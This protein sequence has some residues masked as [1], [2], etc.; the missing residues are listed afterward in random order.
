MTEAAA[1][2]VVA[3]A[4]ASVSAAYVLV[5][6]SDAVPVMSSEVA[7]VFLVSGDAPLLAAVVVA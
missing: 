2:A 7:A 5:R 3:V 1:E 4:V 6:A